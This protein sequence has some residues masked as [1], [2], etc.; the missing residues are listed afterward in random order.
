M[1]ARIRRRSFLRRAAAVGAGAI[2]VRAMGQSAAPRRGT[3]EALSVGLIGCGSRGPYLSYVFQTT[4]GVRFMAAC[5]V[6]RG[7]LARAI[8]QAEKVGGERPRA[9]DNYRRLLDDKDIDAVIIA[10]NEHWHVLP[11]VE[12]CAAGKDVYLE[13][14]VGTSVVEGRAA[15]AAAR[16][17]NRIIQIGTQQRTWEH[18]SL[19][20]I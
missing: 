14:P 16:R 12:A 10:T 17:H 7:R 5:D 13:K 3:N 18:L 6:H 19:I 1:S 8:E 15:V 11:A 9:Y 4:P 20:H 2:G